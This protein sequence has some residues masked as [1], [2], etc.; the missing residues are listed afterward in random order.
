LILRAKSCFGGGRALAD[1]HVQ[2]PRHDI[3]CDT[4]MTSTCHAIGRALGGRR[5]T[6]ALGVLIAGLIAAHCNGLSAQEAPAADASGNGLKIPRYV[7]LKSDRVNLRQGP[8]TEYPIA[9]VFRRA[10][11]PVE[12][13]KEFEAWRQIRDAEGTT[14]WVLSTML[15]GRRT[16][17]ILP[18]E[19]NGQAQG[20][21]K[22]EAKP[23]VILHSDD[24]ERSRAV[25]QVEAGV[26]ASIISCNG[27]WCRVS[28]SG[29]RGY[30]EQ[31]K[32]WG[33]Y[34]GEVIN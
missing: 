17:V 30:I 9:W 34:Q 28:I 3:A 15:S 10:G 14:G 23:S 12:V 7:S 29:F 32:L 1:G 2:R 19:A 24:S 6:T 22:Q 11:L 27:R 26:L 18:W 31:T 25:A 8:G 16:A 5:T 13:I 21:G 33:A 20:D 4:P